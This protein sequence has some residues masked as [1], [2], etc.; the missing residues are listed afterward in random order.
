MRQDEENGISYTINVYPYS[1][2]I[3]DFTW[4]PVYSDGYLEKI[5]DIEVT[6]AR[7]ISIADRTEY[8]KNADTFVKVY[9]NLSSEFNGGNNEESLYSE[10]EIINLIKDGEE[11]R[12]TSKEQT[13]LIVP[14]LARNLVENGTEITDTNGWEARTQNRNHEKLAGTGSSVDLLSVETQSTL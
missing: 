10:E 8:N 2:T 14:T 12:V 13:R 4:W 1:S 7:K 11:F 9:N 6:E 5:N 3:D